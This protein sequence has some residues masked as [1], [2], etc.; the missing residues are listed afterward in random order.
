MS[1]KTRIKRIEADV[2][3]AIE[4]DQARR[5]RD[6]AWLKIVEALEPLVEPI[7]GPRGETDPQTYYMLMPAEIKAQVRQALQE[8]VRRIEERDR[9]KR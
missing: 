2:R 3:P 1:L 4:A 7:M 9:H 5:N 8:R 6:E